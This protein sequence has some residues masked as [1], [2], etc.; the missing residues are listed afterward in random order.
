[1]GIFTREQSQVVEKLLECGL[2]DFDIARKVSAR[3]EDPEILIDAVG[4][5]RERRRASASL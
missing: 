3:G 5:V 1:M 4:T 2:S